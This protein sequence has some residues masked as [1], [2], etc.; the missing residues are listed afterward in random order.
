MGLKSYKVCALVDGVCVEGPPFPVGL[1][2]VAPSRETAA[3]LARR[4]WAEMGD[5]L[6]EIVAVRAIFSSKTELFGR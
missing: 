6:P 4:R 2:V 1:V 5:E 3:G